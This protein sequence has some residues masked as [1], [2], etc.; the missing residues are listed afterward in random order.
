MGV[1]F[2]FDSRNVVSADL[3][4]DGRIDL[5]VSEV[6]MRT[7]STF[8]LLQNIWPDKN[9]WIG[10]R[11]PENI[12]GCTALGAKVILKTADQQI[13]RITAGDSLR[14]QHPA[15]VHFGLKLNDSIESI[16]VHWPDGNVAVLNRPEVDRYHTMDGVMSKE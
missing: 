3:D 13:A 1:A 14:V 12:P 9:H 15:I 11:L 7:G 2:E 8:H 10:V 6:D 16:E 4:A 5:I